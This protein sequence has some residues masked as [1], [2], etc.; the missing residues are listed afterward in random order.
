MKI[1]LSIALLCLLGLSVA[2]EPQ[3]NTITTCLISLTK[4]LEV[5]QQKVNKDTQ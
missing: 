3:P 1:T 5:A 2:S 4:F